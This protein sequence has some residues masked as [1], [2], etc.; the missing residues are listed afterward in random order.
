MYRGETVFTW[1]CGICKTSFSSKEQIDALVAAARCECQGRPDYLRVGDL[2]SIKAFPSTYII[3]A[4]H[5]EPR[6]HRP[7][8]RLVDSRSFETAAGEFAENELT[9][10]ERAG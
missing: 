4:V 2:V 5:Y 9:K 8:Y 3:F 7:I 6:T 10:V 1:H